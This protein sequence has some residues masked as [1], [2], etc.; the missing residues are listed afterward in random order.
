MKLQTSKLLLLKIKTPLSPALSC[1]FTMLLISLLMTDFVDSFT[2]LENEM[3]NSE[4]GEW[5]VKCSLPVLE[6]L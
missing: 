5:K 6:S 3:R 4:A 1:K 2:S